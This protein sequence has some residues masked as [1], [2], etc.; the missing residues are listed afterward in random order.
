MHNSLTISAQKHAGCP[1]ACVTRIAPLTVVPAEYQVE[2]VREFQLVLSAERVVPVRIE[3]PR[4]A[5]VTQLRVDDVSQNTGADGKAAGIFDL[6]GEAMAPCDVDVFC[7][8]K[9]DL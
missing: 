1:I 2:T 5:G 9:R 8:I 3:A 4:V 6:N 7:R